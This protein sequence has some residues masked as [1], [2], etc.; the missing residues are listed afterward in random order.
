MSRRSYAEFYLFLA[1]FVWGGT[2][3]VVK[4]G[5]LDVSPLLL[6]A[7]RF[8]IASILLLLISP[9]CALNA[10][11]QTLFQSA[12]L[13]LFL[14]LGF[15]AQTIGL[16]YTTPS[17]SAFITGTMV[18]FTPIFQAIF[19][20]ESLKRATIIGIC[21]IMVGLWLL[22]SPRG[23]GLNRGDILTLLCAMLFGW[24][25]I[26]L[27]RV[28]SSA[29]MIGQITFLQMA[30]TALFAWISLPMIETP[31]IRWTPAACGALAYTAIPATL[32]T[33]AL[34]TRFQRDTSPTRAAVIFT[35]EPVWASALSSLVLGERLGLTELAGGGL[36]VFGILFSE[37]QR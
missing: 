27:S 20:K 12:R 25:T 17:R 8:S 11:R 1:T 6:V 16:V 3:L 34:Q 35:M 19:D 18:I 7:L 29:D 37:F 28:T 33:T 13:G 4:K 10:N 14:F 31:F 2:F 15:A 5:L 22:T 9:R 24:Y 23:E 21:V 26:D 32:I 36:I 30:A